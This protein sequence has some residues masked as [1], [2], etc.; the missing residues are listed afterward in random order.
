MVSNAVADELGN[1]EKVLD[2]FGGQLGSE[3][4]AIALALSRLR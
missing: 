1:Y 4:R 3:A 2:K